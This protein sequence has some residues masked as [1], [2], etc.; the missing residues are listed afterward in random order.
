MAFGVSRSTDRT[1][2]LGSDC[3]VAWMNTD[4]GTANAVD[5]LLQARSPVCKIMSIP[6]PLSSIAST[7]MLPK[8]RLITMTS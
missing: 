1:D 2:M 5:Y 6:P 7:I 8:S 3:T 4:D